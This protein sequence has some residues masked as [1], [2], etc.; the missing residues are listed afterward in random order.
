MLRPAHWQQYIVELEPPGKRGSPLFGTVL[1]EC[2]VMFGMLNKW[3]K[4][5]VCGGMKDGRCWVL[6]L[7]T[8]WLCTCKVVEDREKGKGT[9]IGRLSNKTEISEM[10][11]K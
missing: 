9:G 8:V 7:C 1:D 10:R 11:K 2:A 5:Y 3:R 4:I 6:C